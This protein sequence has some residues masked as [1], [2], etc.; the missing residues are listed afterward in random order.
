MDFFSSL[1]HLTGAIAFA[2]LGLSLVREARSDHRIALVVFSLCCS[3]VLLASGLFHLMPYGGAA[4]YVMHR[5]DH[6]AIFLF[7]AATFTPI[8]AIV[9]RGPGRWGVLTAVWAIA[10][11]GLVYKML[12][13]N[14]MPQWLS[15][16]LYMA[17]GWLGLASGIALSQRLGFAFVRPL[18]AGAIAY[19][20]GAFADYLEW[21]ILLP[22]VI[23]SH[24]FFHVAVLA[25]IACHWRLVRRLANVPSR[26]IL[27]P[28]HQFD[29]SRSKPSCE[30][31]LPA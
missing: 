3:L 26:P 4:R 18:A 12:H 8:H 19:T 30:P 7:I 29:W 27:R 31:S 1:T 20:V 22:Q 24:E 17:F 15:L 23:G 10:I 21:P 11:A 16:T 5:V 25:G 28:R 14:S 13:F 9:F 2:W 6:A